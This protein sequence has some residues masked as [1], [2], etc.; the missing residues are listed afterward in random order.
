MSDLVKIAIEKHLRHGDP[1]VVLFQTMSGP[2]VTVGNML[3]LLEED[4][5]EAQEFLELVVGTA[6]RIIR[7]RHKESSSDGG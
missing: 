6:I 5:P 1:D 4:A 3:K 7:V 2:K